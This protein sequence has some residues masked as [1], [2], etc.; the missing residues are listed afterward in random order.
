MGLGLLL[1]L[2]CAENLPEPQ[3]PRAADPIAIGANFDAQAAGTIG[4][5][6]LW[7]GAVPDVP[8]YEVRSWVMEGQPA[9]ARPLQPNPHLPII[10]RA[11]G[12]V[13]GAVVFLRDVDTRISRPWNHAPVIVEH[14]NRLLEVVQGGQRARVGFIRR[15]DCV[16]MLSRETEFN[17]LHASGAAFFTLTFPEPDQPLTRPLCDKG[18]VE[19]SSNA[20]WYWMR[21]H[22]FVAEHPYYT[23]SDEHGNFKLSQVPP[24]RY[25]LVCWMPNWHEAAKT[26]DPESALV[27]RVTFHEPM[28]LQQTVVLDTRA[29]TS[30][31]F[32]IC[33]DLFKR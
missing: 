4:G 8:P 13:A 27:T 33:A 29:S 6:V 18:W 32:T 9:P 25:Q 3:A 20:G 23:L 5:K 26:R 24:G 15:G 22:L 2:G 1:T 11:S 17:A 10:D 19:L 30:V 14:R 12:G 7:T 28:E 31:D 21:A 16:T